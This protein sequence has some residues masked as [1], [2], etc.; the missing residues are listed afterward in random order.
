M[1]AAARAHV[2]RARQHA[3]RRPLSHARPSRQSFGK[4]ACDLL[5]ALEACARHTDTRRYRH[6][7]TP[8][9][10]DTDTQ[11]QTHSD[12]DT[13]RYRHTQT[14]T[15][16]DT[17]TRRH[18]HMQI[19]TRRYRHTQTQTHADTDTR[20]HRHIKIQTHA[21]TD[22]DTRRHTDVQSRRYTDTQENR[23]RQTEKHRHTN[24]NRHRQRGVWGRGVLGRDMVTCATQS[25][26]RC[27]ARDL[28]G[29]RA[30]ACAHLTLKL[31]FTRLQLCFNHL[32]LLLMQLEA[33][34]T[35]VSIR[36][37]PAAPDSMQGLRPL[38]WLI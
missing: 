16:A 1:A 27:T 17:D 9:H 14:P 8:T 13:C 6:T 30:T 38:L 3:L 19:Q 31:R 7:Q 28:L 34:G 22:T 24:R 35:Y 32:L 5:G 33:P 18:R 29:A 10:A 21:D 25:R 15:H 11:I 23:H 26:T 2:S 36:T 12:T 20:R 37:S 4:S